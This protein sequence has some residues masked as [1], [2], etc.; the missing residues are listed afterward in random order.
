[1]TQIN[2]YGDIYCF[3]CEALVI[4]NKFGQHYIDMTPKGECML[5]PSMEAHG[6]NMKTVQC[7]VLNMRLI[8]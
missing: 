2:K 7:M 6:M 1:M 4:L 5:F 3:G 8:I